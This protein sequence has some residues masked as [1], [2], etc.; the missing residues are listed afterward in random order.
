MKL[1]FSYSD[2][3]TPELLSVEYRRTGQEPRIAVR[4]KDVN[5]QGTSGTF[6]WTSAVKALSALCVGSARERAR[7][8]AASFALVGRHRSP[9]ASLD[10]AIAKK[11]RWIRE[12]F[13]VDK[14]GQLGILKLIRRRNTELRNPGPVE[15]SLAPSVWED[16]GISIL[17]GNQLITSPDELDHLLLALLESFESPDTHRLLTAEDKNENETNSEDKS[18]FI[19]KEIEKEVARQLKDLNNCSSVGLMGRRNSL[20]Q[21]NLWS[22]PVERVLEGLSLTLQA[23]QSHFPKMTES[24]QGR[25]RS[26]PTLTFASIQAPVGALA[27]LNMAAS[28]SGLKVLFKF[29]AVSTGELTRHKQEYDAFLASWRSVAQEN[30]IDEAK[31]LFD[32]FEPCLLI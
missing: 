22:K 25:V 4:G 13:G 32:T 29:D 11:V 19:N 31:S 14:Q 21:T 3:N 2:N 15:I 7:E 16:G 5:N 9:A 20:A 10:F 28:T 6:Q 27:I 1:T 30:S 24:E 23:Q 12:M 26:L 17:L 18:Q 8:T